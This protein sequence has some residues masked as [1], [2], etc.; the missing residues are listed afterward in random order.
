MEC[1]VSEF[2]H[3]TNLK[4]SEQIEFPDEVLGA[5]EGNRFF[6]FSFSNILFVFIREIC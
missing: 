6:N 5:I 3:V 1:P 2:P 4:R